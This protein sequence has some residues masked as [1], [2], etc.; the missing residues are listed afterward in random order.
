MKVEV[1]CS[2]LGFEEMWMKID[3]LEMG[4]ADGQEQAYGSAIGVLRVW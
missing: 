2:F 1:I 4:S 3:V